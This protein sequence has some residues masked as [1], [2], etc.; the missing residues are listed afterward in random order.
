M[1]KE[2]QY[3]PALLIWSLC[4]TVPPAHV[5]VGHRMQGHRIGSSTSCS[6]EERVDAL[7]PGQVEAAGVECEDCGAPW[8]GRFCRVSFVREALGLAGGWEESGQ[9]AVSRVTGLGLAPRGCREPLVSWRD[10]ERTC[11]PPWPQP[12]AVLLSPR[13][14]STPAACRLGS[15]SPRPTVRNLPC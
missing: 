11:S 3:F 2:S 8:Q 10:C 4:N 12:Q 1:Q 14:S 6:R 13:G 5:C 7:W 15:V 9:R